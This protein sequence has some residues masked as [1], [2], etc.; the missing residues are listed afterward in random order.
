M[1]LYYTSNPSQIHAAETDT[2]CPLGTGRVT[3]VTP[4]ISHDPGHPTQVFGRIVRRASQRVG[5]KQA[6]CAL[7]LLPRVDGGHT[8]PDIIH[9]NYD[10]IFSAWPY[11]IRWNADLHYVASTS[12]L[13][14]YACPIGGAEPDRYRS[15]VWAQRHPAERGVRS[16]LG[17]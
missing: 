3:R 17:E 16:R 12:A 2:V 11:Q 15:V 10:H 13:P 4:G 6:N 5:P 14:Q 7:P 8:P 1:F 9:W